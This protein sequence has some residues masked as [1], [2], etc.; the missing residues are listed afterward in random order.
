MT[1]E[2]DRLIRIL[3]LAEWRRDLVAVIVV[4]SRI[5]RLAFALIEGAVA[6]G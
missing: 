6:R 4:Q 5:G 1:R 3:R 2:H